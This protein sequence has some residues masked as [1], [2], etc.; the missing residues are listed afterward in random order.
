MKI[1][2]ETHDD[3][4]ILITNVDHFTTKSAY[5]TMKDHLKKLH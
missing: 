2:Y 5:V 4:N 3:D 1:D